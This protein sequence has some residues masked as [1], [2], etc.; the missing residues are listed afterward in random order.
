MDCPILDYGFQAAIGTHNTPHI[1]ICPVDI[2]RRAG[3]FLRSIGV[4]KAHV[5]N[6][7]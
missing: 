2:R 1:R 3:Y 7:T 6:D 4:S 5:G